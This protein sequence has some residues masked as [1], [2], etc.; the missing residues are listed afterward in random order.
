MR[1]WDNKI[2]KLGINI[3]WM[4][5]VATVTCMFYAHYFVARWLMEKVGLLDPGYA[6][7]E[8]I[9]VYFGNLCF[10]WVGVAYQSKIDCVKM[11]HA[12]I[13]RETEAKEKRRNSAL[14]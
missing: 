1:N 14:S 4:K 12:A 2:I 13:D 3:Y 6:I 8:L 7:W 11:W 9:A 5:S 10:T